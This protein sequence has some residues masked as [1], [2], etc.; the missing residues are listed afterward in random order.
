MY[1]PYL[2]GKQNEL[3]ALRNLCTLPLDNTRI[4]TLVEPVRKLD[5]TIKKTITELNKSKIPFNLIVNPKVGHLVANTSAIHSFIDDQINLG[6]NNIVPAFILDNIRDLQNAQYAINSYNYI[7]AVGCSLVIN[8]RIADIPTVQNFLSNANIINTFIKSDITPSYKQLFP[9][10]SLVHL[11]DPF[12]LQDKNSSYLQH[13]IEFFT[14]V[15]QYYISDGF[16]GFSD[17]LA[18]GEGYSDSGFAPYAVA[19]HLTYQETDETIW[20][21][22][23]VSDSNSDNKNTPGKFGEALSKLI[24][25]INEK[26]LRTVACNEFRS[27]YNSGAYCGLGELKKLSIMHHIELVQ[28]I[29]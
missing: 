10:S 29:I 15:H 28:S 27:L 20:V 3:I 14:D 1:I 6:A 12:V 4:S 24:V 11:S 8:K 25:F 5:A 19:I 17:Y 7:S 18:I 9:S 22:H 2:R 16:K 26:N 23:F 21:A 13:P